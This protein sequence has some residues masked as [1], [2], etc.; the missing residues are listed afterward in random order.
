[1]Q[2]KKYIKLL[3]PVQWTKNAFVFA[4]LL[5][6]R[7]FFNADMLIKTLLGAVAFCLVSGCV[8]IIND[9][10][11]REKDK[12][13]PKKRNRPIASGAVSVPGAVVLLIVLLGVSL[14]A[15]YCLSVDFG[16]TVTAYFGLNLAYSLRLKNLPILD[17]MSVS[18]GFVLRVLSGSFLIGVYISPWLIICTFML[19]LFIAIHKRR[20][21]MEHK[22]NGGRAVLLAYTPE[23][24]RDMCSVID[25]A[26]I[27][28][29]ALYCVTGTETIILMATIPFVIYGLFR[30]QLIVHSFQDMAETPELALIK[31]KPLLIDILLWTALCVG[32]LYWRAPA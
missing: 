6:S 4:V 10:A 21:E 31:D 12:A 22:G 23:M 7:N 15:A 3:R 24:L 5:F 30:Y 13:H 19:S 20:N 9:I 8:Y 1:M 16:L 14:T 26:T 2:V 27:I 25:S 29:Y 32:I 18:V 11:D 17:I 28:S